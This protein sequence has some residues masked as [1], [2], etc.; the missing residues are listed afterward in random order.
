VDGGFSGF[1]APLATNE[2]ALW[3][4]IEKE[5]IRRDMLRRM[6]L[7]EEVRRELA[8]EGAFGIGTM[9]RPV[10][11][12]WSDSTPMMKNPVAVAVA[13][14]LDDRMGASKSQISDKDKL[15]LLVSFIT[16]SIFFSCHSVIVMLKLKTHV[17]NHQFNL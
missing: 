12:L 14:A 7:E 15:I 10:N 4:E 8:M 3:R 17:Q 13:V 1:R 9:Q 5:Q 11:S 2:A 16:F 6:E